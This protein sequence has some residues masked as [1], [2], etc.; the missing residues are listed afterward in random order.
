MVQDLKVVLL[1]AL[2]C[3]KMEQCQ[4]SQQMLTLMTGDYSDG[5][6]LIIVVVTSF[7]PAT[8][9]DRQAGLCVITCY[10]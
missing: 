4:V 9:H 7:F 10:L 2:T 5:D 3:R 1:A 6:I 8:C